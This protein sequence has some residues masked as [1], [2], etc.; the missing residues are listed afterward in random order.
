MCGKISEPE[1]S[2]MPYVEGNALARGLHGL[3][4]VIAIGSLA[5]LFLAACNATGSLTMATTQPD[6]TVWSKTESPPLPTTWPPTSDTVWVRYTFAYGNNPSELM[7]G[8][9]VTSPL[10]KTEWRGGTS[11][12]TVLSNDMTRATVQGV[13]PLDEQT[14]LILDTEEQVSAYCLGLTDLPDPNAPE[15][16]AML[17]YYG[18]WFQYNGAFLGLIRKDHAGFVEWVASNP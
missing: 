4:K 5:L 3:L 17:A 18:M 15:T 6:M 1:V 12:T 13:V 2:R 11:T 7:D 8:N 9:Y 10:S 14:R 16:R